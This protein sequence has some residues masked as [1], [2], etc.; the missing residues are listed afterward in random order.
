MLNI[1][2]LGDIVGSVG[3]R[4]LFYNLN[5]L[6]KEYNIDL[7]IANGE[8]ADGGFGITVEIA[9]ELFA[10]G[11]DVITSGNHIWQREEILPFLDS[12][13]NILRPFNYPSPAPGKGYTIVNVKGQKVAVLNLQ[14]RVRMVHMIDCPFKTGMVALKKLKQ[15]TN[16]IFIDLHAEDTEERE[17]LALHFDGL[18]TAVCGTHTHVQT[19]DETILPLGTAHIGDLG[20]CGAKDSVI[21]SRVDISIERALSQMP[22]KTEAA[23]GEAIICGAVI[24]TGDDGR[25]TGIKRVMV[26]G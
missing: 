19:A 16:F 20:M 22:L 8:N 2:M 5:S 21:G 9:N 13:P 15:E 3:K 18:A 14:G 26:A 11:I 23:E 1:L 10:M 17:A 25:A 7:T 12:N 24:T 6:K 4:A